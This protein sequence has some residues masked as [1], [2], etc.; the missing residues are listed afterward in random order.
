MFKKNFF[1]KV[2]MCIAMV[3]A[4]TCAFAEGAIVKIN[5]NNFEKE[6]LN[7]DKAVILEFSSPSCPPCLA[8]I[9]TIIG[10][11]KN[12]KDLK[13]G[14][15]N[16]DDADV[17]GVMQQFNIRAFPTF[18]LI[19]NRQV[20]DVIVGGAN[21]D[22]LLKPFNIQK[23]AETKKPAKNAKGEKK[24]TCG[25]NSEFGG[26]KNHVTISFA[27]SGN[28]IKDIDIVTDVFLPPELQDRRVELMRRFAASGKGEVTP[29]VAGLR[30]HTANESDF[31][32]AMD[33]KRISTFEDV[34]AALEL[35]GFS[36]K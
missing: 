17:A 9:P 12:Y 5:D 34:K 22:R 13:V 27:F 11:A 19:K 21:E 36:C 31:I 23:I 6:I 29:T 30:M 20:V 18:Y 35:Q 15:V 32:K 25:V 1:A 2:V 16:A 26:L 33:M 7:T 3:G 8:M 14:S 28:E 4:F 24:M 10:L